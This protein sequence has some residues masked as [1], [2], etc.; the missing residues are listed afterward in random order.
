MKMNQAL[1]V[2]LLV[3]SCQ[4]TTLAQHHSLRL[5]QPGDR[6]FPEVETLCF[7]PSGEELAI[8]T[9]RRTYYVGV[10]TGQISHVNPNS[11]FSIAYSQDG[12]RVLQIGE[13]RTACLDVATKA[14]LP[15]SNADAR[16]Y[17]GLGYKIENGKVLVSLLQDGSPALQS[18]EI[19]VGDE[20]VAIG[21]GQRGELR[22]AVGQSVAGVG[23]MIAGSA[24][25]F[26][27]LALLP[28]DGFERKVVTL[29]RQRRTINN[30]MVTFLDPTTT[31]P[32]SV[33][34]CIW[35]GQ[36]EF[37]ST[38]DGSTIAAIQLRNLPEY[39]GEPA[40]TQDSQIYAWA[41]KYRRTPAELRNKPVPSSYGRG[42]GSVVA[43]VAADRNAFPSR[44][45]YGVEIY[46]IASSELISTFPIQL[47]PMK[48]G[49]SEIKGVAFDAHGN[50]LVATR[51]RLTT[52]SRDSGN[53]LKTLLPQYD[54]SRTTISTFA[55]DGR[56]AVIGG[57][58]G[59]LYLANLES[60]QV[61]SLRA[62]TTH[63][64]TDVAIRGDRIAFH[65]GGSIHLIRTSRF[66][67][68]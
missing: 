39:H 14:S 31:V 7:S 54:P 22:S 29:K 2:V 35:N 64:I 26:V 55:V 67:Q 47:D 60:G 30:G 42:E 38:H 45:H 15:V 66:K 28:E 5:Q 36:H 6:Y 32:D 50:V 9:N 65:T 8:G 62:S 17:I 52:Y 49:G 40:V 25:G 53:P 23:E 33:A 51:T 56:D 43:G 63:S 58:D 16:G 13:N 21:Q 20:L 24:G 12:S 61:Q 18:G 68:S 57:P 46:R 11:S 44:G 10:E 34:W 27:R 19:T 41:G 1:A 37:R 48:D 3:A 4:L 59:Y